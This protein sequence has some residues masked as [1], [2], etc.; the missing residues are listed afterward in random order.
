MIMV[1][2][3]KL[4]WSKYVFP[5]KKFRAPSAENF[6]LFEVRM[7]IKKF[8]G[9]P[10]LELYSFSSRAVDRWWRRGGGQRTSHSH[11]WKGSKAA[12][13]AIVVVGTKLA[14][15][16][17]TRRLVS[18]APRVVAF[19][20][21]TVQFPAWEVRGPHLA[22]VDVAS[23]GRCSVFCVTLTHGPCACP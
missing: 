13:H 21:G 22:A 2:N 1:R 20:F 11:G 6:R 18:W 12:L 5:L 4:T 15:P 23:H 16:H 9:S 10:L 14:C 8:R 7:A 17:P 19:P 3:F